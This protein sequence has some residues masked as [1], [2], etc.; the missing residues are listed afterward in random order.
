MPYAPRRRAPRRRLLAR[1]PRG[2]RT[3]ERRRPRRQRAYGATAL[4]TIA[5]ACGGYLTWE[6]V[7]TNLLAREQ[8][9]QALATLVAAW[10]QQTPSTTTHGIAVD[11]ILR[12]PRFGVAYAVPLVEGTGSGSLALGVGHVVGSAHPGEPGNFVVAGHRVT[13]GEPFRRLPALQIGDEV[14]VETLTTDYIY[15]VVRGGRGSLRLPDTASWVVAPSPRNPDRAGASPPQGRHLITL[16]T[17]AELFHTSDRF[18]VFG[19]LI[20]TR[21]HSNAHPEA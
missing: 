3:G 15:R 14:V 12:V 11:G 4:A 5:V 20:R 16:L 10:D 7:G 13:H 9:R 1:R 2:H 18:V 21:P 19:E 8:Q 6:F 17:C